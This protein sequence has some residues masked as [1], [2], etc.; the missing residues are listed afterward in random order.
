VNGPSYPFT[1]FNFSVEL[2]RSGDSTRLCNAA[3]SECD[4]LE[5]GMEAK[6]LREGGNN[7]AQ[8]RLVGAVSYGQLLLRRGMTENFDLWR[9]FGDTQAD[10]SLRADGEVVLLAAD[11]K[12]E[13]LRFQ[14]WRCLPIRLRAPQLNARDGLLAVEE[15]TL[16]YDSMTVKVP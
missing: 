7:A 12:T 14:L 11:G 5:L 1:S 15:L 4:G 13:R 10:T 2:T 3:F 16:V 9:W 8:I 6:T